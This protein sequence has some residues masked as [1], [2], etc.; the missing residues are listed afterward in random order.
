[1]Q[2]IQRV[3][4]MQV[5]TEQSKKKL[6]DGFED[7]KNTLERECN[8]LYFQLRKHEKENLSQT[9]TAQFKKEIEKRQDKIKMIDFQLS[10]VNTLPL[11]S[12]IKEK[13]M[14]AITTISVGDSWNDE[15]LSKTIVVKNGT[16]IE[17]R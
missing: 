6:L 11:G 15:I 17:I 8:Q 3:T 16:V 2:I 10:Q 12:E 13:E 5:L 1:M 9:I 4:V 7:K 14:D